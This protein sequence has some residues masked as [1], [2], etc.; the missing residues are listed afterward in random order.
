[1]KKILVTLTMIC[2]TALMS[3]AQT[4]PATNTAATKEVKAE[5]VKT[6]ASATAAETKKSGC[7]HKGMSSADCKKNM[8][9]CAKADA[10]IKARKSSAT[11]GSN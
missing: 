4:T 11:G 8:K 7:C 10:E 6:E 5:A 1:M 2:C 3:G 9:N